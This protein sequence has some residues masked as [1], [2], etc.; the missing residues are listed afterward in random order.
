MS[1]K[2]SYESMT[3]AEMLLDARTNGRRK[4]ELDTISRQLRIKEEFLSALENGE[5]AKIPYLV[6]ILG[7]ARNY[8]IELGLDPDLIVSKIKQELQETS[9]PKTTSRKKRLNWHGRGLGTP[10]SGFFKKSWKIIAAAV[11]V[12]AAIAAAVLIASSTN[13]SAEPETPVVETAMP[14]PEFKLPIKNEFGTENKASA[15]IAFQA[16]AETWVKIEDSR[17]ETLFSRVLM[18]GD[19]Y[20]APADTKATVGN[21]G[22]LD[23]FVHGKPAAKLGASGTKKTGIALTAESLGKAEYL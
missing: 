21:A 23:V 18:P 11:L 1:E 20:F 16:V 10:V 12:A 5:Y 19:I 8:A 13:D 2:K 9:E 17:K 14:L 15:V 3:A 4:R 7:F 6:Y 22:G